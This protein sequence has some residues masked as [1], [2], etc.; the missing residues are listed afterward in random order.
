MRDR[1]IWNDWRTDVLL[2]TDGGLARLADCRDLAWGRLTLT[3]DWR[4]R[5]ILW[6][7]E[8]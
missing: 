2:L 5:G 4:R 8:Y 3:C 6:Y 1:R 7:H